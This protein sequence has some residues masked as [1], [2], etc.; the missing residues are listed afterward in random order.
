MASAMSIDAAVTGGADAKVSTPSAASGLRVRPTGRLP[1][2]YREVHEELEKNHYVG[3][4][5]A[6]H[7]AY[8]GLAGLRAGVDMHKHQAKRS[9]DETLVKELVTLL[10][11]PD[12]QKCWDSITTFDPLGLTAT[13]PTIAGKCNFAANEV[14]ALS[15]CIHVPASGCCLPF[16]A[17]LR[18]LR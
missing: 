8:H 10:D 9:P 4:Y 6:D 14:V 17:L 12:V 1:F 13:R 18:V 7:S 5:G 2:G 3:S 11:N 16:G 15:S